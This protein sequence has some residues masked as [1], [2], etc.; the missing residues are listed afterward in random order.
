MVNNYHRM[1]S[2]NPME[3]LVYSQVSLSFALPAAI[4]PL[5]IVTNKAHIMG[6]FKN[7]FLTNCIGWVIVS[8][9]LILNAVLLYLT[10]TGQA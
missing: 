4:I 9:I 3:A 7:S 2:I 1:A 5:M 6:N 10:L 8:L